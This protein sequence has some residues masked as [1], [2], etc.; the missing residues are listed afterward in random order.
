MLGIED[1]SI[2]DLHGGDFTDQAEHMRGAILDCL[3]GQIDVAHR[4]TGVQCGKQDAA[5]ER[6]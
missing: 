3:P 5:L 2:V 1:K 6:E 4:P